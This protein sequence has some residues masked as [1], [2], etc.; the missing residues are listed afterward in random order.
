M[1]GSVR[2][3]LRKTPVN[4]G[5][6]TPDEFR[7][8]GTTTVNTTGERSEVAE[9]ILDTPI[10]ILSGRSNP[11]DVVVPAYESF[12]SD[13]TDGN[14]ETFNLNNDVIE[15]PNGQ[16]VIVWIGGTYYGQPDAV[17]Y[18]NDTIDV[19][20]PGSNNNIYVWYIPGNPATLEIEKAIPSG[21]TNSSKTLH[22]NQLRRL[23]EQKQ[24]EQPDFFTL[25]GWEPYVASDMKLLV[26]VD[27]PY[28]V[29]FEDPNGDGATPTNMRL[30][31]PVE[32]AERSVPGLRGTIKAAMG[33]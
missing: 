18:A 19:T 29:R 32:R 10:N 33:Q 5:H 30:D 8:E 14:T 7:T 21:E 27:A 22:T 26:Y 20:D 3:A 16:N 25:S 31:V 15:S 13:G 1:A 24:D 23:H 12:S 4:P 11:F 2:E 6:V 28:T 9:L 17:D